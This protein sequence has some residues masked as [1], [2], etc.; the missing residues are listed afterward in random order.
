M[1][2][3]Q[4]LWEQ[5]VVYLVSFLRILRFVVVEMLVMKRGARGENRQ[6]KE[7]HSIKAVQYAFGE[8]VYW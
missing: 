1:T 8:D 3:C 2:A 6:G 7:H 4:F 5:R